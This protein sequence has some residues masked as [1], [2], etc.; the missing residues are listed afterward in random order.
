MDDVNRFDGKSVSTEDDVAAEG[1]HR[2][3]SDDV[4]LNDRTRKAE[5]KRARRDLRTPETD[6]FGAVAR[7]YLE[8]HVK[9]SNRESTSWKQS[10][11]DASIRAK[12]V[13]FVHRPFSQ[14]P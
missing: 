5:E 7:D 1:R 11:T 4:M 12:S 8:G 13:D 6:T 9:K 10:A 3:I 2:R 14:N